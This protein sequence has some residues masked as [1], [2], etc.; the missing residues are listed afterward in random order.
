MRAPVY[1]CRGCQQPL[2]KLHR[3][4]CHAARAIPASRT[5]AI[6]GTEELQ[7]VVGLICAIWAWR[8]WRTLVN[9]R[10]QYM[11]DFGELSHRNY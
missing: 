5:W 10:H 11:P 2:G 7:G 9:T 6:Q 8:E 1:F 4:K 3:F